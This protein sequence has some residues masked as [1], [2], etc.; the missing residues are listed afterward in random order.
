MPCW[1]GHMTRSGTRRFR[2][3]LQRLKTKERPH[4]FGFGAPMMYAGF[5][6]LAPDQDAGID[7]S[8]EY[9]EAK[10]LFELDKGL[11]QPQGRD[12]GR[13]AGEA[14]RHPPAAGA[15]R[16]PEPHVLRSGGGDGNGFGGRLA[17]GRAH[18]H[19]R[20]LTLVWTNRRNVLIEG[21]CLNQ[22]RC[23]SQAQ[24]DDPNP[25]IGTVAPGNRAIALAHECSWR[26]DDVA[27]QISARS[28]AARR[29]SMCQCGRAAIRRWCA[30]RAE[31]P[32]GPKALP[33]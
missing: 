17:P 13:A 2:V 18:R 6:I 27:N 32:P 5:K 25:G 23:A 20:A 3:T 14:V 21:E 12:E 10:R 22:R 15:L 26:P 28:Q 7:L 33:T 16:P 24:S 1:H 30:I 29:W 4:G 8:R 19:G 31:R 9:A 11:R